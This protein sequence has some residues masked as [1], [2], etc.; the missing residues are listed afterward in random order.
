MTIKTA[1]TASL[2]SLSLA[3]CASGTT[4]VL[5]PPS[6]AFSANSIQIEA[7]DNT[8]AV[9]PEIVAYYGE[10]LHLALYEDEDR[11]FAEG[12][13]ITVK[14]RFLQANEGSQLKRWAIG[15][16]SGKGSVTIESVFYDQAGNELSRIHS[17]GEISG[18]LFGG[19]FKEAV[20]RAAEET[21]DYAR[22]NFLTK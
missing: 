13:D 3:A 5:A 6:A 17:G 1:L 16:G 2:L 21:A 22:E 14:Y 19:T 8:V 9:E 7:I 4:T 12:S 20:E 18:G 11:A 15:V 10:Q